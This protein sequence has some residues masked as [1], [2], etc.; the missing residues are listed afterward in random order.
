[1]SA[2]T[3]GLN[4]SLP[5]KPTYWAS[6][7]APPDGLLGDISIIFDSTPE[8]CDNRIMGDAGTGYISLVRDSWASKRSLTDIDQ[9]IRSTVMYEQNTALLTAT[10]S[11][12]MTML[13]LL[14]AI[15]GLSGGLLGLFRILFVRLRSLAHF[16]PKPIAAWYVGVETRAKTLPQGIDLSKKDVVRELGSGA[17]PIPDLEVELRATQNQV[18]TTQMQMERMTAELT[19]L[20][21]AM[22]HGGGMEWSLNPL[23]RQPK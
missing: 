8:Y 9:P 4:P 20:R 11:T 16:T 1:M 6:T 18:M 14:S 2:T 15:I 12:R 10:V 23:A 5:P 21:L 7:A 13:Q 19:E 22:M 3:S 17:Y